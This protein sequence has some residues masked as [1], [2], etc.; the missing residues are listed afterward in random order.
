MYADQVYQNYT[1]K[2]IETQ[3]IFRVENITAIYS[4]NCRFSEIGRRQRNRPDARL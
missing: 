2:E 4:P 3:G 1:A